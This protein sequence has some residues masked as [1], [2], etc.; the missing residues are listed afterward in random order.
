MTQRD[1]NCASDAHPDFM[2]PQKILIR[3]AG[4]TRLLLAFL[5][6]LLKLP[7]LSYSRVIL[8]IRDKIFGPSHAPRF[9]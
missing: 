9:F 4:K 3:N 5:R 6:S 7:F 8:E 1:E 2:K